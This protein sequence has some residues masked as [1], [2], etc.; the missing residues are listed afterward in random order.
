MSSAAENSHTDLSFWHATGPTPDA[1]MA[2]LGE[3]LD[4]DVAIVGAGFTGLWTAYYLKCLD[5]SLSLAIVDAHFPGYGA[6]GRN[7]GWCLGELSGMDV[8]LADGRQRDSAIRLQR[9]MFATVDEIGRVSEKEAID[10]HW[11]KGG[12]ISLATARVHRELIRDEISHWRSLGFGEEDFRWLEAGECA[13]RINTR[14]HRGGLFSPHCAA[15]HPLRLV[16]GLAATIEKMGVA[17]YR[18][19]PALSLENGRVVTPGGSVRA[20]M[21]VG[22]TEAYSQTIPSQ[23]RRLL[24]F[25]SMMI[26]TEKLP[27]EIWREIGLSNRETFGDPRRMVIY[28]QRT[29][30]DRFAFGT[31]GGYFFGSG[32]RDRFAPGEAVFKRLEELL[33]DL[34]PVISQFEITHRWGGALG[35]PRDW[36]PVVGI[37]RK[38]S[39]AWAGGYVGE[40]VAATNLAGRTLA[41]L[42]LERDSAL[43]DLAWV[44]PSFKRWEPEPLRWLATTGIGYLGSAIDRIELADGNT[45]RIRNAIY[46]LLVRK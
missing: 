21:V 12:T 15:I 10:C 13:Q 30:D 27:E 5:P 32:I 8:R 26:A 46:E 23:S 33:G 42:I 41:D 28:G 18:N 24:P 43:V 20:R 22:A 25:H 6:S 2:A 3:D 16:S 29:Q 17:L 39:F 4:V 35:I 34:F 38:A 1:G 14:L 45:P 40:G 31:R 37:D 19:T 11:A 36:L 9:E 7:G 44:G